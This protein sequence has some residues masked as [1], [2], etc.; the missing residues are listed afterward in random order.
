LNAPLLILIGEEDDWTP[1]H[2]CK[3]MELGPE[4]TDEITLKVYPKAYHGFDFE[5]ID[6]EVKGHKIKYD[7]AAAKD[8]ISQVKRF[9]VKHLQ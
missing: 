3:N 5:G 4:S 1:A 2:M 8:A 6:I 7:P 9:L